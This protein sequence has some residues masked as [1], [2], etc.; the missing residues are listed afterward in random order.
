MIWSAVTRHRFDLGTAFP[1]AA[2]KASKSPATNAVTSHRTPN[3][4][5]A[6][7]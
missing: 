5:S 3:P 2:I 1:L 7:L 4:D 6:A